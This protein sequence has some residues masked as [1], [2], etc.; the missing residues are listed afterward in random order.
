MGCL[1]DELE[2]FRHPGPPVESRQGP[3][4]SGVESAATIHSRADYFDGGALACYAAQEVQ[5]RQEEGGKYIDRGKGGS[6][7]RG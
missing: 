7:A 4:A 2:E 1:A 5:A 3:L 6:R